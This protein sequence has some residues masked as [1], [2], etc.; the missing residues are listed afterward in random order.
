MPEDGRE[1]AWVMK[2]AMTW[3]TKIVGLAADNGGV[4]GG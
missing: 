3:A 4:D 1:T 2:W